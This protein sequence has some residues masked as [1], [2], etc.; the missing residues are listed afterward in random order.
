MGIY[1][2]KD[3]KFFWMLLE[4]PHQKPICQSTKIPIKAHSAAIR[5]QNRQD[6]EDVYAAAM[7]DL[8]RT[9]HDLPTHDTTTI[10]FSDYADWYDRNVI[11]THRGAA[12]EREILPHLV[13]F[14]RQR[15]LATIDRA[16]AS[17]YQ[18]WRAGM[19]WRGQP[20]SPS[21]INREVALL[22]TMLQVAVPKYLKASPLAGMTLLR[23]VKRR[24]R[25]LTYAE[26]QRL[27]AELEPADQALY[28]V[29]VDTLIR[30]SN[31][32]NLKRSEYKRTHL[33]LEDSKTGPYDV[34]LSDRARKALDQLPKD[35][36]Y[37]FPHRRVAAAASGRR[38]IIRVLLLKACAKT[39]PP[40]PYGRAIGGITWHTATR[41]TGATRM[42]QAGHDPKTV[43]RVGNWHSFDQMGEYLETDDARMHAAVNAVG[44]PNPKSQIPNRIT[45]RLRG[46]RKPLKTAKSLRKRRVS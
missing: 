21:T 27:L 15:D 3:S 19:K 1:I 23:V 5:K 36:E 44:N 13:A 31:V 24:K 20:I 41:A 26:E 32:L 22:K 10:S 11:A 9:R 7:G 43:Q 33:A 39:S 37:F 17:E 8:A 34:P 18:T 30:L 12:R 16:R 45:S 46:K 29:A 35:G 6:A 40:I 14:F 25:T 38:S 4:R 42:L 2:R 28:V